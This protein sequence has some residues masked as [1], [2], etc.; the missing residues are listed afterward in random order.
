MWQLFQ[1]TCII[2]AAAASESFEE[3]VIVSCQYEIF[4]I[5]FGSALKP[6]VVGK[7]A[8]IYHSRPKSSKSDL[9]TQLPCAGRLVFVF[10]QTPKTQQP[11]FHERS[12]S[13]HVCNTAVTHVQ[14]GPRP[15]NARHPPRS[16]S[17]HRCP[18]VV[19][20]HGWFHVVEALGP[21]GNKLLIPSAYMK[22]PKDSARYFCSWRDGLKPAVDPPVR[23]GSMD[24]AVVEHNKSS[25]R[26]L[27]QQT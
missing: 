7:I 18:G 9:C 17:H 16:S 12:D 20:R 19:H 27:S 3:G 26:E 23:S 21:I 22:S 25:S 11:T 10:L 13:N 6:H 2:I 15:V 4:Q 1:N 8:I 24:T 5:D 14:G